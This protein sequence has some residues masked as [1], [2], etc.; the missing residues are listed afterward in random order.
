MDVYVMIRKHNS[1]IL[2]DIKENTTI[3]DL[4]CMIAPLLN[5]R[6]FDQLLFS[7]DNKQMMNSD[8]LKDYGII[9]SIA[10]PQEPV[11]LSLVVRDDEGDFNPIDITPYSEPPPLPIVGPTEEKEEEEMV[12]E[13]LILRAT[14]TSM[15]SARPTSVEEQ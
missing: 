6:P 9:A 7:K 4:K 5:V 13:S 1:T 10:T 12:I 8:K 11:Q 15:F 3:Y 14:E 2:L